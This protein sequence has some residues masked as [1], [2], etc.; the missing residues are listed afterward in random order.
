MSEFVPSEE[1]MSGLPTSEDLR[2]VLKYSPEHRNGLRQA[3]H[4]FIPEIWPACNLEE[5]EFYKFLLQTYADG[6]LSE[7][8]SEATAYQLK[9][10]PKWGQK[11]ILP[12]ISRLFDNLMEEVEIPEYLLRK[13]EA[14]DEDGMGS[15]S[16]LEYLGENADPRY[17]RVIKLIATEGE[18]APFEKQAEIADIS[19]SED[20]M[21]RWSQALENLSLDVEQASKDEPSRQILEQLSQRIEAL[22]EIMD[23]YEEEY[24]AAQRKQLHELVANA[25]HLFSQTGDV[26]LS[27]S[28]DVVA[29]QIA[30][31]PNLASVQPAD[32]CAVLA[33]SVHETKSALESVNALQRK[34]REANDA[35]DFRAVTQLGQET[36][37]ANQRYMEQRIVLLQHLA[38]FASKA[39]VDLGRAGTE[40]SS[41]APQTKPSGHEGVIAIDTSKTRKDKPSVVASRDAWVESGNIIKPEMLDQEAKRDQNDCKFA[42]AD[43]VVFPADE[44]G[45]TCVPREA[46]PDASVP[47]QLVNELVEKQGASE[48]DRLFPTDADEACGWD[49]SFPDLSV[50]KTV[51]QITDETKGSDGIERALRANM[52]VW[53]LLADEEPGLAV[54]IASAIRAEYGKAYCA[55]PPELIQ[56]SV[57]A[58]SVKSASGEKASE[59]RGLISGFYALDLRRRSKPNQEL[60]SLYVLAAALRPSLVAPDTTGAHELLES[61]PLDENF[62]ALH[63]LRQTI[64]EYRRFGFAQNPAFL[65]T[66]HEINAWKEQLSRVQQEAG[67]W[68]VGNR[69][70][71]VK[72]QRATTVWHQWLNASGALGR[73]LEILSTSGP[74]AVPQV[75][76]S[77]LYWSDES[78][79][80]K[81]ISE[82]DQS[83]KGSSSRLRPIEGAA[84]QTLLRHV[85]E[86]IELAEAWL[87][88]ARA[89]PNVGAEH[90]RDRAR[91]WR[92]KIQT[93][94]PECLKELDALTES[95]P[96]SLQTLAAATVAK[97][98]VEGFISVLADGMRTEPVLCR[99]RLHTQLLR[100][101]EPPRTDGWG[102]AA[103][104]SLDALLSL[105]ALDNI[106]WFEVLERQQ[107]RCDLLIADRIIEVLR[108]KIDSGLAR[109]KLESLQNESERSCRDHL[110]ERKLKVANLIE[111]AVSEGHIPESERIGHVDRLEAIRPQESGDIRRD[112]DALESIESALNAAREAQLREVCER[113]EATD[114]AQ[115][116]PDVY[117]R[118]NELLEE[119]DT[120]TAN[121]YIALSSYGQD[122]PEVTSTSD[123]FLDY[124]PDQVAQLNR[125]LSAISI[126]KVVESI[127]AGRNLGPI[128]MEGVPGTQATGAAE[129]VRAWQM[130]KERRDPLERHVEVL[131]ERIGFQVRNVELK[132]GRSGAREQ[133]LDVHT[134]TLEDRD[135]SMLPRFGSGAG[136]HYRVLCLWKAPAEGEV[137]TQAMPRGRGDTPVIVLYL[138]RMT[139]QR[140]RDLAYQ[141]RERRQTV[142][143]I[144]ETLVFFLCT[145]RG[146]RLPV[147]F[148]CALPFTVDNPYTIASSNVPVEMFFGRRQERQSLLDPYGSN[149][150]YGGRQLGKTALLREVRREKH[151]P[152]RGFVVQLVDLKAQGIGQNRAANEIWDVIAA[153]LR[154]DGIVKPQV[155]RPEKV[156]EDITV[157]LEH[158]PRRRILLLLDEADAFLLQDSRENHYETLDSLKGLM[159]GTG[160]RFKIV[161]AGL[162]NVQRSARDV[163]SPIAHLGQPLCVGPLLQDGEVKEALRL[164]QHPFE[165]L[166][167]RFGR[168]VAN[169]ILAHTNYYP[170]LI[171]I[172]CWHLLEHLNNNDRTRFGRD[173]SPPYEITVGHVEEAYKRKELRSAIAERFRFTLELDGRYRLIALRIALETLERR[174]SEED[175]S[176]G[177]AVEWI[178]SES[179]DLWPK[180]FSETSFESFRNLLDEMIGLGILRKAGPLE[181]RYALRSPN[182]INLLGSADEIEESLLD[183]A[184]K[185]PPLVYEAATYR[186][187]LADDP[188]FR[189][190]ITARQEA[191]LIEAEHGVCLLFGLKLAG[192]DH[193]T[194]VL[195]RLG[196]SFPDVTVRSLPDLLEVN[197]LRDAL[198]YAS[199]EMAKESEGV[200]LLV[201]GNQTRWSEEWVKAALAFARKRR[202]RKRHFR[203]L[204]IGDSEAAWRWTA[205]PDAAAETLAD[206]RLRALAFEPWQDDTLRRWMLDSGFGPVHDR[207]E[208]QRFT[209]A[210][211]NWSELVHLLGQQIRPEASRWE[212][213]VEQFRVESIPDALISDLQ[214]LSGATA[215]VL[216]AMRDYKEALTEQ[217]LLS[218]LDDVEQ[219]DLRHVLRW[220]DI[221]NIVSKTGRDRWRLDPIISSLMPSSGA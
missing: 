77:V 17:L 7:K 218:L 192:L 75:E 132:E 198:E 54:H 108:T 57:L 52:L 175:V 183:A 137:I 78:L 1:E 51:S 182:V 69:Q 44:T 142:L 118:I 3:Y 167:Y 210:T 152:D 205:M 113:L 96:D 103:T 104:V 172:F 10:R 46:E 124:F 99:H 153:I 98:A 105:T 21:E 73:L 169:R 97:R 160:R 11:R 58:A 178:R 135:A 33:A 5:D 139:E 149:L 176:D 65:R 123:A 39:G 177:F 161:L 111:F 107:Q 95:S 179:L 76:A 162:H 214:K 19:R 79:V 91:D 8:R 181:N 180:G 27:G 201:V 194:E 56:A 71:V 217:D 86:I 87:D 72:F 208:R 114:L 61:I 81:A 219:H 159:D 140:R 49:I 40:L 88:V 145:V 215:M 92:D 191:E 196:Q 68:W 197:D 141:C 36:E 6:N 151:A 94:A 42:E 101:P 216:R 15:Q 188:W 170:S 193:L 127:R 120:L 100:L 48:L 138:S 31:D 119:G 25:A 171:Q 126:V 207:I 38:P 35:L 147:M 212:E 18:V 166:G 150:V 206:S 200:H 34:I 144:D 106:D 62:R 53:R 186:R 93:I 185:D 143:V 121:E 157:W 184:D 64:L 156:C 173:G 12:L 220:A 155:S 110:A 117:R 37:V 102:P 133:W 41:K 29:S 82:T 2:K 59:L 28:L 9:H 195:Q 30:E 84:K 203:I 211:G 122:I 70:R 148:R 20:S 221:L 83:M 164:I 24:Q 45:V 202:E 43:G 47:A 16:V 32:W 125:F 109:E 190:P 60:L 174:Q 128:T 189:S 89:R 13:S 131:L 66:A 55:V 165:A 136:G 130:A 168:N 129:M 134:V 14:T 80:S 146:S 74:E 199:H 67:E 115:K 158:D 85:R 116:K 63:Q 50:H 4:R 213:R 22:S 204:F 112:L 209:L 26:A 23:D 163:N 154:K 90:L 187:Y